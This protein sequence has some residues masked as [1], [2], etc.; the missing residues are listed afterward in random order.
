MVHDDMLAVF[1]GTVGYDNYNK[2]VEIRVDE[3]ISISEARHRYGRAVRICLDDRLMKKE[4]EL[5]LIRDAL[6][7]YPGSMPLEIL[8]E[9]ENGAMLVQS[10]YQVEPC[11]ELLDDLRYYCDGRAAVSYL[12]PDRPVFH[13]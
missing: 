11:D 1:Y 13:E 8:Y 5:S 6:F 3:I 12:P 2:S 9:K 4:N 10:R 7:R